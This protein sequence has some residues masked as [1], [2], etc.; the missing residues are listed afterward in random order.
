MVCSSSTSAVEEN[1]AKLS[2]RVLCFEAPE[3]QKLLNYL[4]FQ[5]SSEQMMTRFKYL[6]E[7]I[8]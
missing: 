3:K 1:A 2:S 5:H 4:T 8:L 7:L 6:G